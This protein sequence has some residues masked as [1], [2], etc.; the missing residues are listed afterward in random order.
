MVTPDEMKS[1]HTFAERE[2][3]LSF[4]YPALTPQG[5]VVERREYAQAERRRIHFFSSEAEGVQYEGVYFE[6]TRYL[7]LLP[8]TEYEQHKAALAAQ[9]P[10]VVFTPLTEH[11][12]GGMRSF[13]Y[14]FTLSDKQRAVVLIPL[15]DAT[16][17][18]LYNPRSPLNLDILATVTRV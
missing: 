14:T 17:R 18:L 12:L 8:Q 2:F 4:R 15:P 3:A 1:W 6:I 10:E 13:R 11:T 9:R 5:R 7:D 16:Y